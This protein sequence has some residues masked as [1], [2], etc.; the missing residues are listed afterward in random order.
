[1]SKF[2]FLDSLVMRALFSVRHTLRYGKIDIPGPGVLAMWHDELLPIIHK[3]RRQ[4]TIALVSGK[5]AGRALTVNMQSMGHKIVHGSN[6]RDSLKAV[7]KL[8]NEVD[9]NLILI[10]CDGP[11]GPRHEMK[12]GGLFIA[13]KANIPLYLIRVRYKGWRLNKSWDK[14]LVPYPFAKVE[15][16]VEKFDYTAD[17]TSKEARLAAAEQQ[18]NAMLKQ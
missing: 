4:P 11:R 8:L 9:D 18:L 7:K 15:F 6:T 2:A 5:R 3:S 17:Y 1:M 16:I 10:A 14:F 13:A 12:P